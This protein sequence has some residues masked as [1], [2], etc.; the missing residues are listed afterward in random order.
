MA[1]E[2]TL[3]ECHPGFGP[4]LATDGN[5]EDDPTTNWPGTGANVAEEATTV[6]AG[7][8][9]LEVTATAAPG[10]ARQ[11][12]T[13]EAGER[14]RIGVWGL[15]DAAT[16]RWR[17]T[18][19]LD[20]TAGLA[21][22]WTS[23]WHANDT[24]WEEEVKF[25]RVPD[26]ITT[27]EVR[28]EVDQIG[29]VV[30][31]DDVS[32]RR[33]AP[34]P[35]TTIDLQYHASGTAGYS[36]LNRGIVVGRPERV[37]LYG[38]RLQLELVRQDDGKRTIPL[39]LVIEGD[40]GE[41][42]IDRINA[43]EEMLRH[44]ARYRK[45]G[46]GGEVFLELKIDDA[47]HTNWFPVHEGEIDT[48]GLYEKCGGEQVDM[49]EELPLW[50]TCEPYWEADVTYDLSNLLDNP[51]FEEWNDGICNSEPD[52][53]DDYSD[54]DAAGSNDQETDTV[55][56]GCEALRIETINAGANLY[57]GVTQDITARLRADTEYTL[58]VWVQNEAITNGDV[59]VYAEGQ[60]STI[61]CYAVNSG[62]ANANYTR[63]DCQFT[64][65]ATDIANWVEIRALIRA[66]P[67]GACTGIVHI[68]KMLVMEASN[69]P[70]GW[71]SSSYL[72]NHYDRDENTINFLSVCD[73]PGEIDAE[74]KATV[75][76]DELIRFLRVAK[77]TRDDPCAFVWHL[78]PCE[79][80]TE[81]EGGVGSACEP[82]LIDAG[83]DDSDKII[84][85]TSPS[86]SH[87][88]VD[89]AGDKT[90]VERCY[91]QIETNLSSYY[92]KYALLVIAKVSNFTD[93][94]T[95]QIEEFDSPNEAGLI[96]TNTVRQTGWALHDGWEL[97][98]YRLGTSDN[99]LIG[100]GNEWLIRLY[101]A[102]D[103]PGAPATDLLIAGAY[104]MA[105]DEAALVAG[106]DQYN[107][108]HVTE[109]DM[110]IKHMDGDR[111]LFGYSPSLE[112]YIPNVGAVGAGR[113]AGYP[114][115]TPEIENWLYFVI[116]SGASDIWSLDDT[117]QV[118][119]QYRPRGIFLRGA[120]P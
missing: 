86:G 60:N 22:R 57:Q 23:D 26:G 46:W 28:L 106:S 64:P 81:V 66:D 41:D 74:I 87:I 7:C 120:N 47:T 33:E 95:M 103:A 36:L 78:I 29:D 62:A 102:T 72:V 53:W 31:F 85:A 96:H 92:G 104:L 80:Y 5:M 114:L 13:V 50:V 105:L 34:V 113:N 27:I 8:L 20:S 100:P 15:C 38:G 77:R 14:Y 84:D 35:M 3:I 76:L 43:L 61:M 101:A 17:V 1:Y 32:V 83:L 10:S 65:N 37:S 88:E 91:W 119:I 99:D 16:D 52:C 107:F 108:G 24:D 4:E 2:C 42:L 68:D 115:L 30:F 67:G 90:M 82:V 56:E 73:I 25:Y 11:S 58:L 71:M 116:T 118:S 59:E 110:I 12:I 49:I 112:R 97:L 79:A 63:Y 70:T 55:E 40:D 89:F 111:G 98:S 39:R 69:V 109:M 9:A 117:F 48:T 51:G 44:A 93:T 75:V 45:D 94:I 54:A 19:Y 21:V 6:H 18:I